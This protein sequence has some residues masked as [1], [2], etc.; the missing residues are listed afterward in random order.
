MSA[1]RACCECGS[2]IIVAHS[3][4]TDKSAKPDKKRLTFI[5][6]RRKTPLEKKDGDPLMFNLT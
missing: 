3:C 1:A 6:D 5:R 4:G 2:N